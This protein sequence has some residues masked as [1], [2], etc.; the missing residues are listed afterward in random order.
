MNPIRK[1][2]ANVADPVK[3]VF[4]SPTGTTRKITTAIASAV[5]SLDEIFDLTHV[6]AGI[7][8]DPV[9][10]A[11]DHVVLGI[12]VYGG[13]VQ[14]DAMAAVKKMKGNGARCTAVVVYGNRAF[15]DALLELVDAAV[16]VG[17][18]PVAAGAFVAQ[19]SYSTTEIPIAHGRPDEAD[20]ENAVGFGRAVK[21]KMNS[22][23][24]S[25]IS[26]SVPGSR[27]FR[28]TH[29]WEQIAPAMV[30]QKCIQC[31]VCVTV[32]PRNSIRLEEQI[33]TDPG[34]CIMC[35]ACIQACPVQARGLTEEVQAFAKKLSVGQA[36][37]KEP[38]WY[39]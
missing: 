22:S 5:G 19:H 39:L 13:R 21:R 30:H 14:V 1:E 23:T 32:C 24:E 34:Q 26:D 37:R 27:P 38:V 10:S 4:F 31:E 18:L 25:G 11:E 6:R 3:A 15:E 8:N 9:F 17:F 7:E 28:E 16:E 35:C 33:T 20:L 36:D 29:L 12:P 2:V